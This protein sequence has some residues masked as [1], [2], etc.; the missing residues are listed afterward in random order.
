[1]QAKARTLQRDVSPHQKN[2]CGIKN[3]IELIGMGEKVYNPDFNIVEFNNIKSE[4]GVNG[5]E[6]NR[7][8]ANERT[9]GSRKPEAAAMKCCCGREVYATFAPEINNL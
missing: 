1:L 6:S 9:A 2:G 7:H 5:T 4:S 8:P 3:T